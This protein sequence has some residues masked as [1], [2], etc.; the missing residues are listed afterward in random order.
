MTSTLDTI[1]VPIDLTAFVLSPPCFD[2]SLSK[3]API[4]QPNYIG[5]RINDFLIQHDVLEQIDFHLCSPAEKNP[6]VADLGTFDPTTGKANL[7]MNRLGVYLHW[8]LPRMYRSGAQQADGS[9]P[10]KDAVDG[11]NDISNPTFRH[12]PNRWLVV[13]HLRKQEPEGKLKDFQTWVIESNR[14][15]NIDEL[16]EL[17]LETDV[18]PFVKYEGDGSTNDDILKTQAEIFI[19]KRQQHSGWENFADVGWNEVPDPNM[20]GHVPLTVMDT[21]NPMFPGE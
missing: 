11:G 1:L 10:P 21:S 19:G 14:Q 20:T 12:V 9:T 7:R 15:R 5:L 13:R 2:S 18:T 3:I 8:S 17:D 16:D 6:R 4:T